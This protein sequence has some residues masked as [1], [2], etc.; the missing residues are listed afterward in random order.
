MNPIQARVATLL[1]LAGEAF[2]VGGVSHTGVASVMRYSPARDLV[3]D[4]SGWSR[5]IWSLMVPADAATAAGATVIFRGASLTV[6]KVVEL[7][8]RGFVVAK[9]LVVA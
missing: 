9:R 7:R 1:R 5:P 4:L 8:I 6:R 2:T 3:D